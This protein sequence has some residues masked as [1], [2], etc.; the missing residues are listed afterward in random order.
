MTEAIVD[1]IG[2][3]SSHDINK[4][5]RNRKRTIRLIAEIGSINRNCRVSLIIRYFSKDLLAL[6][7]FFSLFNN[8][9]LFVGI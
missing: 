7:I 5:N 2:I 3:P 9:N 8:K 1:Q 4:Y 6:H